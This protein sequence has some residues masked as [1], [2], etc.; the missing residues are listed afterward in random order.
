MV[1]DGCFAKAPHKRAVGDGGCWPRWVPGLCPWLVSAFVRGDRAGPTFSTCGQLGMGL[2]QPSS[3]GDPVSA[4]APPG[5]S[6]SK[7]RKLKSIPHRAACPTHSSA[8]DGAEP[9]RS[10]S[11][12]VRA[13][14]WALGQAPA[15]H[16]CQ[17]M[18][19]A[20]GGP[21]AHDPGSVGLKLEGGRRGAHSTALHHA[22][23]PA[24][25]AHSPAAPIAQCDAGRRGMPL[26]GA[27]GAGRD[28]HP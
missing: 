6:A 15:F 21:A 5:H 10:Q 22:G 12:R 9:L 8:G 1:L 28:G 20:V 16:P 18:A 11:V 2:E 13:G 27:T 3:W 19:A 14:R 4:P 7:G 25:P 26:A 23:A 17:S 24:P